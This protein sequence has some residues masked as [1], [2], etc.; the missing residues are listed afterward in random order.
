MTIHSTSGVIPHDICTSW[1][2][3]Y[4]MLKEAYLLKAAVNKIMEM[5]DMKLHKYK[6][7]G[8]EWELLWQLHDLLKAKVL[9]S[10]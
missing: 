7:K 8:H 10:Y 6:I 5:H 2:A 3:T 9:F 4:Y 1:N